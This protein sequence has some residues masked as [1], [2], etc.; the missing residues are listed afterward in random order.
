[1]S[2]EEEVLFEVLFDEV[3]AAINFFPVPRQQQQQQQQQQPRKTADCRKRYK[4]VLLEA[5]EL[6]TEDE[7]L[8]IFFGARIIA[9]KIRR[10]PDFDKILTGRKKATFYTK[11]YKDMCH[12]MVNSYLRR[13]S[14]EEV[15]RVAS[16][17]NPAL[18]KKGFDVVS[19]TLLDEFYG[20]LNLIVFDKSEFFWLFHKYFRK[21][22]DKWT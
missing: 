19:S 20:L 3:D 5:H 14:M 21:G 15:G 18:E 6:P 17:L 13:A 1:M 16:S 12:S 11:S 4:G 7:F 2:L 9:D 22:L 10:R 8:G